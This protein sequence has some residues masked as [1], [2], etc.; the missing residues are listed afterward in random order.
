MALG[1]R[2]RPSKCLATCLLCCL[3]DVHALARATY[4]CVYMYHST[5]VRPINQLINGIMKKELNKKPP[6][7]IMMMSHSGIIIIM[8]SSVICMYM[9]KYRVWMYVLIVFVV[10]CNHIVH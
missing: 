10:T 6:F 5:I 1:V 4:I 9:Y 2:L 3:L 8:R 7:K